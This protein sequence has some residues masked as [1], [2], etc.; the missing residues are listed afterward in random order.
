MASAQVEDT[1]GFCQ[2]LIS[3]WVIWRALREE[4][5][6]VARRFVFHDSSLLQCRIT[7]DD[8]R[9]AIGYD[10]QDCGPSDLHSVRLYHG[11][12]EYVYSRC[13]AERV[14]LFYCVSDRAVVGRVSPFSP[15][16]AE[17]FTHEAVGSAGV[18]VCFAEPC[19]YSRCSHQHACVKCLC[20]ADEC[21][22]RF[23]RLADVAF[24]VSI[25]SYS[26]VLALALC[27]CSLPFSLSFAFF[28]SW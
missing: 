25:L 8:I 7:N 20:A 17:C 28:G 18:K 12:W 16:E 1:G 9:S 23:D 22:Y 6:V 4:S 19:S 3:S 11:Q 21:L 15:F 24:D 10:E 14:S 2:Q 26:F 27:P 5:L 13:D